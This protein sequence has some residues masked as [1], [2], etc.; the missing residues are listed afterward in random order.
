MP[1]QDPE[2]QLKACIKGDRLAQKATTS[3]RLNVVKKS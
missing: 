2:T 1:I 3:F